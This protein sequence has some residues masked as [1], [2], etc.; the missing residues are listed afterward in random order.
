MERCFM[1]QWVGGGG[2]FQMGASFLSGGDG[3]WR[4]LVWVGGF[5][6]NCMMG[7]APPML[8]ASSPTMQ[9]PASRHKPSYKF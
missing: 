3:P 8:Y 1:F 6:K 2:V 7:G 5:Q 9:N 4:A